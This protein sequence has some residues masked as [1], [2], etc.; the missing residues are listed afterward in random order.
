MKILR[1]EEDKANWQDQDP[2]I[3]IVRASQM[4]LSA[5]Q[6]TS[7]L[8]GQVTI[9]WLCHTDQLAVQ[10]DIFCTPELEGVYS[11]DHQVALSR[12]YISSCSRKLSVCPHVAFVCF[13][14][15]AL[16]IHAYRE[17]VNIIIDFMIVPFS[18]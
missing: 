7:L 11:Q 12:I 15:L 17:K 8:F 4:A 18:L 14:C 1:K 10:G 13:V 5:S 2:D 9:S 6:I 3:K 16:S